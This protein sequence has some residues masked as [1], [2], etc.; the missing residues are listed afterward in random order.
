MGPLSGVG[1]PK[2]RRILL[3]IYTSFRG[4][5]KL[6]W[7]LFWMCPFFRNVCPKIYAVFILLC[8]LLTQVWVS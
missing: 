2:C 3:W 4:A 1:T 7:V 8:L 6:V 5:P